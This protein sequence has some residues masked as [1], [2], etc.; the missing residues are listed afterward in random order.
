MEPWNSASRLDRVDEH[1]GSADWV[2]CQWRQPDAL[3][4]KIDEHGRCFVND[5]GSLRMTRPFVEFDPERHFLLGTVDDAPVFAVEALPDGP[6]ASLREIIPSADDTGRDIAVAGVALTHWHRTDRHCPHEGA[7]TTV[8]RGGFARRCSVGGN[9]IFPRSDAAVIVAIRD[10]ADR[11][12]LAHQASW[13]AGR[14]SV[15][16]GFVEAGESFEQAV[17]REIAEESDVTLDELTYFGSQPW[18]FPRSLMVGFL[19][20]AA[21]EEITVDG[22]E[23]EWARWY[24]RQEV[25]DATAAGEIS[26]PGSASIARRMIDAWLTAKAPAI[27]R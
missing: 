14:V 24:T 7:E 6:M 22:E 15:L 12:L 2:A 23:I 27:A 21:S 10:R 1:R 11:L 19:A 25:R 20:R 3:L 16:A 9:E 8:I 13:D 4:L 18:P 5:D 17:H 26:L